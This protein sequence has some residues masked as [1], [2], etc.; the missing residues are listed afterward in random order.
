VI[1]KLLK[2]ITKPN[3][4]MSTKGDVNKDHEGKKRPVIVFRISSAM[5]A[6]SKDKGFAFLKFP[7]SLCRVNKPK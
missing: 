4:A 6:A 1:D 7:T 5:T 2:E 3:P